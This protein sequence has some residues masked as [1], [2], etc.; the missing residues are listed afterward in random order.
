MVEFLASV[1]GAL[2]AGALA[3]SGDIGGKAVADAY[4]AF[5]PSRPQT[6]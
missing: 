6:R 5:G 2:S 3:K 1:I 4:D